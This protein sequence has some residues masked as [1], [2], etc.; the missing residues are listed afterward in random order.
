MT[1]RTLPR[2]LVAVIAAGA[3]AV[4]LSAPAFAHNLTVTPPG[5]T[6]AK[7][8]WVGGPALPDAA[9]GAEGLIEVGGGPDVGRPQ[10][11]SHST[12][13]NAACTS[14]EASGTAVVDIRGPGPSCPHGM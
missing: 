1:F 14:L 12:G 13:L 5:N 6:D 11:P 9:S 7:T 8:G 3:L 2:L 4:A 10:P